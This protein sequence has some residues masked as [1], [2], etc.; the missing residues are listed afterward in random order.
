LNAW[1]IFLIL[2]EL[3]TVKGILPKYPAILQKTE[4]KEFN[5]LVGRDTLI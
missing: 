1:Q 2:W 4:D 5:V 3:R